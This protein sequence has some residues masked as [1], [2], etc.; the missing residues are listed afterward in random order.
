MIAI[1]QKAGMD[2][3]TRQQELEQVLKTLT[4]GQGL[5]ILGEPGAGKSALGTAVRSRMVAQGYTVATATYNGAAK[6]TLMAIADQ[7]G[8]DVM[9][10]GDRPKQKTAQQL[11]D[12][13]AERLQRGQTLLVADDAQ[14]WS[15]SLRYWLEALQ[16][17]GVL[18]L[19]LACDPPRK[20]VF[21]K[22]PKL[23]LQP[24]QEAEIRDLMR[25]EAQAQQVALSPSDLATLQTRAGN[26][27]ALARRLVRETAL[28]IAA[29]ETGEHYQYVDGTPF[30]IALL[31][32][33]G[34][35]RF[36]GLGLGDKALYVLGGIATVMVMGVRALLYA[37]NRRK[38]TL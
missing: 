11:R 33:V 14:R 19:L 17:S 4:S 34:V 28:G 8:V 2:I 15:A 1:A 24:L 16:R 18:L 26:N 23:V 32:V 31:S 29:V 21:L 37:V 35:V 38:R 12:D 25:Q 20:D 7:V 9:T 27:P 5:L 3:A 13:L 30:L 6:E 10:D 22:L 36:I